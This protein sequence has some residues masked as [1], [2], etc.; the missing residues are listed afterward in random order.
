MFSFGK[1]EIEVVQEYTYLGIKL[2]ASE[3]F[4]L[5]QKLLSEK[6]LR[7]LFKI[8]RHLNISNISVKLAPKLFDTMV[9]PILAY[10]SEVWVQKFQSSEKVG[11]YRVI[12][13]QFF[14]SKDIDILKNTRLR[15]DYVK[16]KLSNHSL[17]IETGRYC[18][19]FIDRSDRICKYCTSNAVED[20]W[21]FLFSCDFYQEFRDIYFTKLK[22]LL[23]ETPPLDKNKLLEAIFLLQARKIVILTAKFINNCFSKRRQL[24]P[25]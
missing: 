12:K 21:Y 18:R 20:E 15:K 13:R 7:A 9:F 25:Q 11:F 23:P 22:R 14:E 8:R 16:L 10:G 1:R 4:T 3:S 17:H 5:A 19:T 24:P 6:A 2:T